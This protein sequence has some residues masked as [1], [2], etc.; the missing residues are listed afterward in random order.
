MVNEIV[1][2]SY[3]VTNFTALDENRV[4]GHAAVFGVRTNIA[5]FFF[6]VIERGAFDKADLSDVA[7]FV[8]HDDSKIPLARYRKD[9]GNSTMEIGIDEKGLTV[10]AGLDPENVEAKS[11]YSAIKRGD[12]DG[13]SFC[14][15]VKG[16]RWEGLD[17]DMPTRY[18]SDI[19]KVFEV[20]AVTYPA[21]GDT[22]IKARSMEA[23][24]KEL[25]QAKEIERNKNPT[26]NELEVERLKIQI[27]LKRSME[28]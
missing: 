19:A 23:A 4:E 25:E 10:N 8:N 3:N 26:S 2:R 24:K 27:N 9:K 12:I 6:E 20:S 5:N 17:T 15:R 11:L 28:E 7:L 18:I 1:K 13:M 14:F 16:E 21:Y 22:D